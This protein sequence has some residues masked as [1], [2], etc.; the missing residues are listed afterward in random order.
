M[1]GVRIDTTKHCFVDTAPSRAVYAV[2]VKNIP[3]KNKYSFNI[4][5]VI[6][7]S[8]KDDDEMIYVLDDAC[9]SLA[10]YLSHPV[11]LHFV[12]AILTG[13][14][15]SRIIDDVDMGKVSIYTVPELDELLLLASPKIPVQYVSNV[16]IS[17]VNGV[18]KF[19]TKVSWKK[20]SHHNYNISDDEKQIINSIKSSVLL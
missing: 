7:V 13:K 3:G 20:P 10:Q 11:I 15:F 18:V 16:N 12:I 19:I 6:P 8:S 4:K 1:L 2:V 9:T 17:N 5:G 14:N